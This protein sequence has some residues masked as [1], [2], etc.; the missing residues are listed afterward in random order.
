MTPQTIFTTILSGSLALAAQAASAH[1][2]PLGDGKISNGPRKGHVYSCQ[3]R[4]RKNAPGAFRAGDWLDEKAG[5][6]DPA[7]K[8]VVDGSVGWPGKVTI[9]R[10][11]NTRVVSTNALPSGHTTGV[12]PI[13][14]S[15]D[16]YQ[17]DR[18]PNSIRKHKYS[19]SLM[20]DPQLAGSPSCVPM[21]IIGFAVSGVAI[22]NALD[23]R[24]DD[25]P[26]HE[27]Q[28]KCNGHPERDGTYH[29]HSLSGCVADTKSGPNG[30]SDLL[31]YSLDG[32]GIYGM[33]ENGRQLTTA[34]L[35]ECHGRTSTVMWDGKPVEMYHYVFT[36]D[37]PYTIGCFRGEITRSAARLMQRR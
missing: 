21:G 4:F 36:E 2:L 16:A 15:D 26:A 37:Y 10:K 35:D 1:E 8:P 14:R 29:Y 23:A 13:S 25:A 30:T 12:Y 11:G 7:A 24:G 6:W 17:Y 20:A 31:G 5:T 33:V 27:I 22:F 28:D 9:S 3:Q 34:D 19:I 32:F 18:N